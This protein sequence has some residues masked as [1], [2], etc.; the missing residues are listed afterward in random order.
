SQTERGGGARQARRRRP[1]PA[2]APPPAGSN[3]RNTMRRRR[4]FTLIELAVVIV[5][6]GVLIALLIPAMDA[7]RH[8]ARR[9]QCINNVRQI[10]LATLSYQTAQNVFPMSATAGEGRGIN[11]SCFAMILPELEQQ[12]LF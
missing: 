12:P 3:R 11:H 2:V 7:A 10:G 5:I 1:L 9:A 4:A 8:A 6:I